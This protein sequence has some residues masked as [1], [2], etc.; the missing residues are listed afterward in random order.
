[1]ERK[2]L[3]GSHINYSDVENK[4]ERNYEDF[5]YLLEGKTEGAAVKTKTEIWQDQK[6]ETE[7][8]ADR[9]HT[10][11][12]VGQVCLHGPTPDAAVYIR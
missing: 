11:K 7:T 1:M 9:M 10:R 2:A 8:N 4:H 12:F 6:L 5:F 3:W